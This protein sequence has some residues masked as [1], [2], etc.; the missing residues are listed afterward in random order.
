M[1]IAF[2]GLP[3]SE[4]DTVIVNERYGDIT[5]TDEHK[6]YNRAERA[7]KEV[8]PRQWHV[9]RRKS[10]RGRTFAAPV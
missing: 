9:P 2:R 3:A 8:R 10:V 7:R 5:P 6:I 1:L 4:V